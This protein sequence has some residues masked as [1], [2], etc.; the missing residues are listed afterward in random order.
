MDEYY[1]YRHTQNNFTAASKIGEVA[2]SNNLEYTNTGLSACTDYYYWVTARDNAEN[3]SGASGVYQAKT[4]G[5]SNN[6]NNTN[7]NNSSSSS[8]GGSTTSAGGAGGSCNVTFDIPASVYAGETIT[9]KVSGSTYANGYFRVTPDGKPTIKIE[10][11]G[12]AKNTWSGPYLIPTPIG[13]KLTFRFGADGCLSS[14]TRI[15]KDPATKNTIPVTT[16]TPT[17]PSDNTISIL[18]SDSAPKI[19][20]VSKNVILL[21]DALPSF[22][23]SAGFNAENTSMR[24]G[25]TTLLSSWKYIKTVNVVP[26]TEEGKYALRITLSME[27]TT[28]NGT[29]KIVEKIPK[30]FAE[31]AAQLEANYPM[32]VLKD[33]PLIQFE[34]SGLTEGQKV[35][36]QITGK[37]QYSIEEANEKAIQVAGDATT[38]SLLFASGTA[39]ANPNAGDGRPLLDITGLASGV[40]AVAPFIVGL[41]A[42]AGIILVSVRVVRGSVEGA[43]NPILRSAS[44]IERGGSRSLRAPPSVKGRKIWKKDD[45]Y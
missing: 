8:G 20:P 28:K 36:V 19:T 33:D 15:V 22:M 39:G 37:E 6:N 4:T 12:L 7:N 3:E 1:I 23:G 40:G 9:A 5:C 25:I 10:Q 41:I 34:I 13:I 43:D 30:S 27:N 14:V 35:D 32:T 24:D 11:T 38:P 26:G 45:A 18:Q 17:T 21:L 2:S 42:F 44:G 31:S 29:I 16:T